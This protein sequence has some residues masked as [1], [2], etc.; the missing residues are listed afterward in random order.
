MCFCGNGFASYMT[1]GSEAECPFCGRILKPEREQTAHLGTNILD[2][3]MIDNKN[4]VANFGKV[5][6]SKKGNPTLKVLYARYQLYI[7]GVKPNYFSPQEIDAAYRLASGEEVVYDGPGFRTIR[8]EKVAEFLALGTKRKSVVLSSRSNGELVVTYRPKT[9]DF[10]IVDDD[11]IHRATYGDYRQAV[12]AL[13]K[14][15]NKTIGGPYFRLLSNKYLSTCKEKQCF[16]STDKD[17]SKNVLTVAS[18]TESALETM[19][20]DPEM[21]YSYLCLLREAGYEYGAQLYM[22]GESA[23]VKSLLVSNYHP[24]V[25]TS[26]TLATEPKPVR[27]LYGSIVQKNDIKEVVGTLRSLVLMRD[28]AEI[29]NHGFRSEIMAKAFDRRNMNTLT[30]VHNTRD[31]YTSLVDSVGERRAMEL[32]RI[33]SAFDNLDKLGELCNVKASID[34]RYNSVELSALALDVLNGWHVVMTPE[35]ARRVKIVS[36]DEYHDS[37][38]AIVNE[39][40]KRFGTR[41]EAY[42]LTKEEAQVHWHREVEGKEVIIYPLNREELHSVGS[43]SGWCLPSYRHNLTDHRYTLYHM[44]I[45]GVS[46]AAICRHNAEN[47]IGQAKLA[48][49]RK[50]RENSFVNAIVLDWCKDNNMKIGESEYGGYDIQV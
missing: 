33:F 43:E 10:W 48:Y 42:V 23:T 13:C 30:A 25:L 40:I 9:H 8:A 49:N 29:P 32:F 7:P 5:F 20:L 4:P 35:G 1:N 19:R 21:Y 39:A 31:V 44:T 12:K 45:D 36:I 11:P 24:L 15:K 28:L 47:Y 50:V 18:H 16:D 27:K 3:R 34:N 22:Q 14:E 46:T 41:E 26:D 38:H 37:I 2:G 6:I 17:W